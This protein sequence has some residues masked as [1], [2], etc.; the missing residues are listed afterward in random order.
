MHSV[1]KGRPRKGVHCSERPVCPRQGKK[2]SSGL[3]AISRQSS[4]LIHAVISSYVAALELRIE[5]LERRLSYARSTKASVALHGPDE[6]PT[7]DSGRKDSMAFI[8]A[9]IHRKAARTQENAD[10]NTLVSDFGYLYVHTG[11]TAA[12][13][14]PPKLCAGLSTQPPVTLNHPS[15]T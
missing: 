1:R 6:P 7:A 8:R 4:Q 2:V 15:R 14:A 9:A 11:A 5:K 13:I 10:I 3:P 12:P